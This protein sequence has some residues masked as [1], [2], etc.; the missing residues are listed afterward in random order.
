LRQD[1]VEINLKGTMK[2]ILTSLAIVVVGVGA[3]NAQVY[4]NEFLANPI[5]ADG[6]N[7]Y[8]ELRGSPGFSLAG[9][10]LFKPGWPDRQ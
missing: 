5:G 2:R 7:E 8:F 4:I 3:A 6:G 10:Y 1:A 9:H